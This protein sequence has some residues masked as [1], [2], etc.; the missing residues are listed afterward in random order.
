MHQPVPQGMARGRQGGT[1]NGGRWRA[2]ANR[3]ITLTANMPHRMAMRLPNSQGWSV[4]EFPRRR[5]ETVIVARKLDEA[6]DHAP[7]C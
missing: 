3:A 6:V 7:G 1:T 5:S 4:I 2:N